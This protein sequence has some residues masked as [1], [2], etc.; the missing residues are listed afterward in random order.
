M[1]LPETPL[2]REAYDAASASAPPEILNHSI[3]VYLL[4]KVYALRKDIAF[5]EEGLY[6]A[7]LFH[8]L[9]LCPAYTDGSRPFQVNGSIGS[10]HSC[11]G[12]LFP[13]SVTRRSGG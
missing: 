3:R 1:R 5:D 2:S 11:L 10:V 9:G 4:G 8:D 13:G 7:A 12:L 6:L